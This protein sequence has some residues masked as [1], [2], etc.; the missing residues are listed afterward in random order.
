MLHSEPVSC[1]LAEGHRGNKN[2]SHDP[3]LPTIAVHG[4]HMLFQR[5]K[6]PH[7]V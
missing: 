4:K 5:K 7:F 2:R 6:Y 3:L 1:K